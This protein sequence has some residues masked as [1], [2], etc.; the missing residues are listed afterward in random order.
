MLGL[1][2][3]ETKRLIELQFEYNLRVSAILD[4]LEETLKME[5]KE[6]VR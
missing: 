3:E 2:P 4:K 5:R 1:S 6:E